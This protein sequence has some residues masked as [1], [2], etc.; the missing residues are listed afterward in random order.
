MEKFRYL[1][2]KNALLEARQARGCVMEEWSKKWD[3]EFGEEEKAEMQEG[4]AFWTVGSR[5]IKTVA[6]IAAECVREQAS[7]EE[8]R[9]HRGMDFPRRS[10]DDRHSSAQLHD[11]LV[12]ILLNEAVTPFEQ[13][14][15]SKEPTPMFSVADTQSLLA[16]RCMFLFLLLFSN[17]F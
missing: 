3:K 12:S 9:R 1:L 13:R 4:E 16:V 6:N 8:Q 14:A 17:F 2:R 5:L 11:Y 15:A 7:E 10:D